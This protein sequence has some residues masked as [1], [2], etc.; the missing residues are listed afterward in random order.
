[1]PFVNVDNVPALALYRRFCATAPSADVGEKRS[2][3]LRA[4]ARPFVQFVSRAGAII[5]TLHW[6]ACNVA[7]EL[8]TRDR[9]SRPRSISPYVRLSAQRLLL[10]Q[11]Q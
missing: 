4:K 11:Q 7:L 5:H 10:S 3:P 8:D 1:M 6:F 9:I 2:Y